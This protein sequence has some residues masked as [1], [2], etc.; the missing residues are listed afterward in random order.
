MKGKLL[1]SDNIS[2]LYHQLQG[3]E[4]VYFMDA[5]FEYHNNG[6]EPGEEVGRLVLMAFKLFKVEY[7]EDQERY[8]DKCE[9]MRNN[10]RARKAKASNCNQLQADATKSNQLQADATKSNQ[11]ESN[12]NY[13]YNNNVTNVTEEYKEEAALQPQPVPAS[14]SDRYKG[15]LSWLSDNCPHLKKMEQPTEEQFFKLLGK[16]GSSKALQEILLAME[17]N[18]DTPKKRRSIYLTASN[19]LNRDNKK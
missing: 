12:N 5:V 7:D 8:E 16:S 9:K 3:M 10:A 15:F 18:T 4:R 11:I 1:L 13:N 19:W 17:N 2:V 6:K 14:V